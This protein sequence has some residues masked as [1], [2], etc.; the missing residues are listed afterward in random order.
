MVLNRTFCLVCLDVLFLN[1]TVPFQRQRENSFNE[2]Q[3]V[4]E[5]LTNAQFEWMTGRPKSPAR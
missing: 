2:F 1:P 4:R 3:L 5:F